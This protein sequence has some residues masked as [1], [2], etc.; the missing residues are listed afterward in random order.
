[1]RTV[2]I[3]NRSKDAVVAE[4]AEVAETFVARLRGLL[5]RRRL[6]DGY[7]MVIR[8]TD[9]IHTFFMA[10]PIDVVFLDASQ[11]VLRVFPNMGKN[12][13]SPLVRHAAC[14]VELPVGTIARTDTQPGDQLA[15]EPM[16]ELPSSGQAGEAAGRVSPV[17]RIFQLSIVLVC[18]LIYIVVCLALYPTAGASA[19]TLSDLIPALAGWL[20]GVW[21]GVAFAVIG[22]LVN[23]ELGQ[24]LNVVPLHSDEVSLPGFIVMLLL[25]FSLGRL[26]DLFGEM[27]QET[28]TRRKTEIALGESEERFRRIFEQASDG[29]TL[30]DQ[31]GVIIEWNPAMET[32]SGLSRSEALGQSAWQVVRRLSEQD[33]DN[34]RIEP[35]IDNLLRPQ[36]TTQTHQWTEVEIRRPNG[37]HRFVQIAFFPVQTDRGRMGGAVLRDV[38]EHKQALEKLAQEHNLLRALINTVPDGIYYK[39]TE[40]R[41]VMANSGV[42]Q[43]MG[44]AAPDE[45]IGKTD[46]DF[47]PPELAARFYADEQEI[48]RT[49]RPLIAHEEPGLNLSTGERTW[50]ATSKVPL[51]DSNGHIIGIVGMGRDITERKRAEERILR[52]LR[53]LNALHTIDLTISSSLDLRV[54][55]DVVIQQVLEQL[56]VDAADILVVQPAS[57]ILEYVAG[58]GF[59]TDALRHTRLRIGEGYAGTAALER[60]L[61]HVPDLQATPDGLTRSPSLKDEGFVCY[62]AMPLIAKGQVKGILEIFHRSPFTADQEWMDFLHVLAQQAAIA[63]DS[64]TLFNDLQRANRDLLLAYDTTL[65]GWSRALDLR[66]RDTEGHSERVAYITEKLAYALGLD[67]ND[68]VHIRRGALLHDIGKLAIPDSILHKPGPL[69][70]EEWEVMRQHPLDGY[71]L[72]SPIAFLRPALDIP[73]CHHEKYDGSG[74]PRGLKGDEIPL[75]ARIF[76]VVD[77]WDALVSERPYHHALSEEEAVEFIREQAGKHFDPKVVEKFLE[78]LPMVRAQYAQDKTAEIAM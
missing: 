76:A 52:H 21:G 50:I 55:L 48:I 15:F 60:R 23:F 75:A 40:S 24:L 5:G 35:I 10:F 6:D 62:Y 32:I 63:I 12:R 4:R 59:R 73:Y 25:G 33:W 3:V 65:R 27:E 77:V 67:E 22:G 30:A 39:D 8:P 43:A 1:M 74:Y 9:M 72:L 20:M 11:R 69:S 37:E 71:R 78:L 29:I 46:M 47:Y 34:E 31:N 64:I 17:E 61:I 56:V 38:T 58:R 54:C 57:Q 45:L 70:D 2:R 16:P 36:P 26:R 28:L 51:R 68:V 13:I 19:F 49:G 66:D 7:G 41:F 14:V 44:V 42:A 53:Q 18:Q